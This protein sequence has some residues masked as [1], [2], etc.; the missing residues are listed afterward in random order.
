[1][2]QISV[3][4]ERLRLAML[5]SDCVALDELV[6]PDLIFTNHFG[7]VLG[8][9]ADLEL[10]RSGTLKLNQLKPSEVQVKASPKF[11]VVSVRMKVIGSYDG[12]GFDEDLRYTRVWHLSAS[13]GWKILTGHSSR[14][15]A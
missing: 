6:S 12:S 13:G 4:E 2:H 7:Q 8:K 9:Y 3:V 11:A 14:V 5:A 15:L 10:H 1:M